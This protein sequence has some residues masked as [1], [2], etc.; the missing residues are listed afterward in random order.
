MPRQ[1][2]PWHECRRRGRSRGRR[3]YAH[4]CVPAHDEHAIAAAGEDAQSNAEGHLRVGNRRLH[5]GAARS[6]ECPS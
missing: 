1:C 6:R 4:T 2:V 3:R 5:V